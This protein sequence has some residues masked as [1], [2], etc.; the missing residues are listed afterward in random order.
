MPSEITLSFE[1]AQIHGEPPQTSRAQAA[2]PEP[3]PQRSIAG[4]LDRHGGMM[5]CRVERLAI[6]RGGQIRALDHHLEAAKQHAAGGDLVDHGIELVHQ[7]GF[8]I[9]R[10]H[11]IGTA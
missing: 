6:G 3:P 7:Q 11:A 5:V 4:T 8:G 1:R 9:G 10:V 2:I